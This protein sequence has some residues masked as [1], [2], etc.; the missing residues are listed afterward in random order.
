M[1]PNTV[2]FD[3][4]DYTK[5]VYGTPNYIA[6]ELKIWFSRQFDV[7]GKTTFEIWSDCLAY[8]WV[9]FCDLFGGAMK[10]P[11]NIYYIPF[12]ICTLFKARGV[13][14]DVNREEFAGITGSKHNAL[15]DAKVIKVCYEKLWY[16]YNP[17]LS[18]EYVHKVLNPPDTDNEL[19]KVLI[20]HYK[21]YLV[22]S[23]LKTIEVCERLEKS[24]ENGEGTITMQTKYN[25]SGCGKE[26]GD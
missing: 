8:D 18:P 20:D 6:D 16:N 5:Y 13:D 4:A 22:D 19:E 24:V 10:V 14:P 9:L 15:H 23:A 7:P 17:Y 11:S 1:E 12:D 25:P 26:S 3:E 2:K 21:G